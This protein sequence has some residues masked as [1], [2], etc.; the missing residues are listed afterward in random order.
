MNILLLGGS[1]FMGLEL[2][3]FYLNF[4]FNCFCLNSLICYEELYYYFDF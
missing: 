3:D 1:K 4:D 2:I